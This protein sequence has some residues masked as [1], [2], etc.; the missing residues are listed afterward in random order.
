ML[1]FLYALERESW[2]FFMTIICHGFS[3]IEQYV[4]R[5]LCQEMTWSQTRDLIFKTKNSCSLSYGIRSASILWTD[6][7]MISKWAVTILQQICSFHLS[8]RFFL[9][10]ARGIKN[11]LWF[12]STITQFSK[13]GLH[14]IEL[15]NMIC[16]ECHAHPILL[17]LAAVISTCLLSWKKNSNGFR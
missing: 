11:H 5:G 14:Q 15:T 12:I 13:A 2:R 8:K 7:Q 4:A 1:P 16:I 3:W 6:S 10:E 9:E 17:D